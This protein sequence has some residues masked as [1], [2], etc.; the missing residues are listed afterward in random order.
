[1][2][3]GYFYKP[4]MTWMFDSVYGLSPWWPSLRL[5]AGIL[6]LSLVT[7]IHLKIDTRK[8]DLRVSDLQLVCHDLT[9]LSV[10]QH[11]NSKYGDQAT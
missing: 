5:P 10:Y 2:A 11:N 1:M 3:P 9:R 4:V 8:F 6:P 7:A